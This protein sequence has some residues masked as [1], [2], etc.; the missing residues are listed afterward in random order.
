MHTTLKSSSNEAY[1]SQTCCV[2]GRKRKANRIKRGLYRCGMCKK[3]YNADSNGAINIANKVSPE[4]V[5][6]GSSGVVNTP[7][8][9]I[10]S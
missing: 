3:V 6:I 2:C 7:V 1:T 8:R 9:I 10:V 4:S 5:K